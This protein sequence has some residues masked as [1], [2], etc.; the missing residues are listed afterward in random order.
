MEEKS[1]P[2]HDNGVI[3]SLI[4]ALILIWSGFYFSYPNFFELQKKATEVAEQKIEKQREVVRA[5]AFDDLNLEAKTFAVYDLE[6]GKLIAGKNEKQLLPLASITKVMTVLVASENLDAEA[7]VTINKTTSAGNG[8]LRQGEKWRFANLAALTLVASSN[9]GATALA[10]AGQSASTSSFVE[11]MNARA[12]ELDLDLHFIN[13]TGLDEETL[14]GGQGSALSVA[15]LFSYI[16]KNQPELLSATKEPMLK[17]KSLDNFGHTVLNTNTITR[18]IPGLMA[19]KT[20]YTDLA[21]G[22]LGIVA[23]IGLRRPIVVVVLGSSESGRFTDTQKLIEASLNYYS[24][25]AP[26]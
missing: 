17:E 9:D 5:S 3:I 20:G 4:V 10:E 2:K 18:N 8:G 1:K 13:P 25:L 12:Q 11:K 15:K 7:K 24:N 6:T 21:G 22:N 14:P 23:N 16:T 26:L 19:S